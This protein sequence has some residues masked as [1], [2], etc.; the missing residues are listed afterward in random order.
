MRF[1]GAAM[2]RCRVLKMCMRDR[3]GQIRGRSGGGNRLVG[4]RTAIDLQGLSLGAG[5]LEFR[6][7]VSI[8]VHIR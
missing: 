1:I 3:R 4:D 8:Q 7:N 6:C 5:S 2:L